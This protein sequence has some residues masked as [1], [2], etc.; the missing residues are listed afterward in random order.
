MLKHKLFL[1][2]AILCGI[3]A[4][5]FAQEKSPAIRPAENSWYI[6]IGGGTS[7]GQCTF[8]SITEE[9][10]RNWGLQGGLFGGY[11]FNRLISL[12]AGFQYGSQSQFN[13]SCCP[14]WVSTTGEWKATQVIDV[15]GW[16]FNDLEVA[17][18]W[19]KFAIQGNFDVLSF[20]KGNE[21]WSLDLS[22]QIS[23][24]NTKS[25]WM[26]ELS[27]KQGYHQEIQPDNWH[28]GLGG[29]V[30]A[31][32]AITPN[33]KV[34]L[35]A[36]ITALTGKRFDCI[37][38]KVHQTNIIWDAGLKLTYTFGNKKKK[39]AELAAA[40]EAARI[41][42][43]QEAAQKARLEAE[44]AAK[45]RAEK[46]AAEIAAREK[47]AA[48]EAAAKAAAEDND[49]TAQ[50]SE[51]LD[52]TARLIAAADAAL[53][54]GNAFATIFFENN[55]TVIDEKG[56]AGLRKVK[57][58]VDSHPDC[59]VVMY[60]F[61]SKTGTV[62]YNKQLS[63]KRLDKVMNCLI[64]MGV[65]AQNLRLS[66]GKGVDTEAKLNREARRVNIFTIEK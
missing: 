50:Q 57:A 17:T 64:E 61:A 56:M 12:E 62:A 39:A 36:G 18:R 54:S 5:A 55:S 52:E 8:Y 15:D 2:T 11:R 53:A 65:P 29:Q 49:K 38:N 33:W 9:G 42:A 22:P 46:E 45:A 63:E 6:G 19:F 7:F 27:N 1:S 40:A 10:I 59:K 31:G 24:I 58:Y 60:G 43:E 34:G 32:F 51:E 44:A 66:V 37:P 41:A 28:L 25:K 13:L 20:I 48:E 30:G 35:Y 14:Y 4:G 21:R 26:G 3:A 16:Y 23:V 47:A